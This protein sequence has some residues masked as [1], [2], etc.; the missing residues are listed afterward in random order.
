MGQW[1]KILAPSDA[2]TWT[3]LLSFKMSSRWGIM[4]SNGVVAAA[5]APP[6]PEVCRGIAVVVVVVVSVSRNAVEGVEAETDT[7]AKNCWL[8]RWWFLLLLLL[9]PSVLWLVASP[10]CGGGGGESKEKEEEGETVNINN[11]LL[12]N[13]KQGWI[14]WMD[15][16]TCLILLLLLLMVKCV[17]DDESRP[18]AKLN[19]LPPLYIITYHR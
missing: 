11:D 18:K 14:G 15:R 16:Y 10:T 6:P 1:R 5:A 8:R 2:W 13:G 19:P 12:P 7:G 3:T 4:R 17:G 9:L